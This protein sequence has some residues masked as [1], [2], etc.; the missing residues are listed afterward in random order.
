[1]NGAKAPHGYEEIAEFY[2]WDP[3]RYLLEG[4]QVSPLW[5]R[6]QMRHARMPKPLRF[7]GR[8]VSVLRVHRKCLDVFEAFYSDVA[9]EG[10]WDFVENTGGGYNFRLKRN[11]WQISMHSFGAATDNDPQRN[12]LGAPRD[13]CALGVG[14]GAQVVAIARRLGLTWGGDF[15]GRK[16]CMHFQFGSGY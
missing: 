7:I 4:G 6:D 9:S 8:P 10:L 2:G 5:E 15:S 12:P 13:E 3:D 14:A 16:D 1:M 11:G